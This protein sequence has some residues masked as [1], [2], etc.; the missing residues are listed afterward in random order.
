MK[1]V[2]FIF[3]F[4]LC[5]LFSVVNSALAYEWNL[6]P[7]EIQTQRFFSGFEI[8][9]RHQK[10]MPVVISNNF[11]AYLRAEV[12]GDSVLLEIFKTPGEWRKSSWDFSQ[13]GA[14]LFGRISS[15]KDLVYLPKGE[16]I[17]RVSSGNKLDYSQL[18]FGPRLKP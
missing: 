11:G 8:G 3:V 18:I 17:I 15:V 16:Y 6:M 1:K 5:F 14:T 12:L 9:Y 13:G 2:F 7:V 10:L 4:I